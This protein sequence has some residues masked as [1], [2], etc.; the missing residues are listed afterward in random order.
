MSP[1]EVENVLHSIPGVREAAVVGAPDPILGEA[2]HAIVV[3]DGSED[4][5]ETR[6]KQLC[7][8]RLELFMVPAHVTFVAEL[9]KMPNGKIDRRL[10]AES[11]RYPDKR[12]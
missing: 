11:V 6:V 4:L 9:P 5:T 12:A 2:V 7:R 1:V 3:A 8:G 10:L